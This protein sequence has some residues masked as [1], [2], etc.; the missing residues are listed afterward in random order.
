MVNTYT[1]NFEMR[2]AKDFLESIEDYILDEWWHHPPTRGKGALPENSN[3]GLT[4]FTPWSKKSWYTNIEMPDIVYD[5]PVNIEIS[6]DG[7][8]ALI[9]VRGRNKKG[10]VTSPGTLDINHQAELE[11]LL[12][13]ETYD[14]R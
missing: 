13:P 6:Y 11:E 4:I 12:Q 10:R 14:W 2:E 7:E 5:K 9:E 3:L 8:E 1:R